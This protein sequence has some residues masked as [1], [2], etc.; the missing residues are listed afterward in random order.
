MTDVVQGKWEEK[1]EEERKYAGE[2]QCKTS[3]KW[4]PDY[5]DWNE[6]VSFFIM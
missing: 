3:I 1:G 5:I 4:F 2:E 6:R